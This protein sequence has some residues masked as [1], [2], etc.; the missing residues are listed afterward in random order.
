MKDFCLI[1]GYYPYTKRIRRLSMSKLNN[2]AETE[3]KDYSTDWDDIDWTPIERDV[4]QLHCEEGWSFVK[5]GKLYNYTGAWAG[6][7]LKDAARKAAI[8][9]GLLDKGGQPV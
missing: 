5:I 7:V 2:V 8:A 1:N 9:W 6:R 4:V 3:R